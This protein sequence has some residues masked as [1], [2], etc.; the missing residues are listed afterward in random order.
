M[1]TVRRTAFVVAGAAAALSTGALAA[2]PA[3]AA[4]GPSG[5]GGGDTYQVE[6]SANTPSLG[7]WMWAALEPGPTGNYQETDCIHLG[8]GNLTDAAAHDSGNLGWSVTDGTLTMTGVSII[9]G[10]ETAT[11]SVPLS[12]P[13]AGYGPI[14]TVTV[15][16]TAASIPILPVGTSLTL[17]A[18]G[19]VAP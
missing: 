12:G 2:S 7:F 5:Y 18:S 17:P 4:P 16:V 3:L 8:G 14:S 9:G 1:S 19:E 15:T 11:V 6:F 10:L 13:G